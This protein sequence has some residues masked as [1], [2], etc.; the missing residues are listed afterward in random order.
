VRELLTPILPLPLEHPPGLLGRQ[1]A[2]LVERGQFI[3]GKRDPRCAPWRKLQTRL[4]AESVVLSWEHP[5]KLLRTAASLYLLASS[6]SAQTMSDAKAEAE[7]EQLMNDAL[8]F[9]KQMLVKHGEFFP[10]GMAMQLDGKVTPVA[11][12]DGRNY[13]RSTDIIAELKRAFIEGARARKYKA[14]ALVY[15]AR[16]V[17]PKTGSRSDAIAV[18]LDHR[19]GYSVVV[20]F[21]YTIEHSTLT[22]GEAFASKGEKGIFPPPP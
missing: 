8:P 6:I 1:R 17:V 5:V 11:T 13:P 12:N 21:P 3:G 16:V 19:D 20:F 15:D 18:S 9:A 2:R 22:I 4:K 7:A 14:T 10:Y